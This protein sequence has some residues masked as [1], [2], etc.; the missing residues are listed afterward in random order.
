MTA[1][2]DEMKLTE[3]E[4]LEYTRRRDIASAVLKAAIRQFHMMDELKEAIRVSNK[5]TNNIWI[6]IAF[7]GGLILDYFIAD[8][9][10]LRFNFGLWLSAMAFLYW[11]IKKY[12]QNKLEL[13]MGTVSE[14]L[15]D[16][17]VT[18]KSALS[19][20]SFWSIDHIKDDYERMDDDEKFNDWWSEQKTAILVN[21]CG[22]EKGKKIGDG[23]SEG[24]ANIWRLLREENDS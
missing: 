18:W 22:Y 21:V 13:R 4:R 11:L 2:E 7:L 16:L 1:I 23:W 20:D 6:V 15:Y 24:E 14:R 10:G 5:Q 3:F 17:E 19:S 12:E 8:G 9:S